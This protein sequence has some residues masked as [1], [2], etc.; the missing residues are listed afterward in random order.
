MVLKGLDPQEMGHYLA[1]A[2]GGMEMVA[3]MVLGVIIDRYT[4]WTP[5]LTVI[6]FILGF[7]GGFMH[8]MV[9]LQKHEARGHQRPERPAGP[10][11]SAAGPPAPPSGGPAGS[12]PAGREPP[13]GGA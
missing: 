6:G 8:L 4:G 12:E 7:V 2:Q 13:G 1:L 9:L 10:G 11:S 5:W 3:P